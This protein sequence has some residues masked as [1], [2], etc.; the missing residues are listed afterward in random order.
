M[1]F[2]DGYH[3]TSTVISLITISNNEMAR[4]LFNYTRCFLELHLICQGI[5][6]TF[7]LAAES[8]TLIMGLED[9]GPGPLDDSEMCDS[10]SC[11]ATVIME[12]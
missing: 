12:S 11:V 1:F 9:P 10:Y 3:A 4:Q 5:L 2:I 6:I 8:R 7:G